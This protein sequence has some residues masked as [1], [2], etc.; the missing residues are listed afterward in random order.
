MNKHK[1]AQQLIKTI[2]KQRG[3]S[4]EYICKTLDIE[5]D[6]F[7]NAMNNKTKLNAAEFLSVCNFLNIGLKDFRSYI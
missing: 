2:L 4:Y 6:R 5:L 3:L 1:D 7:Y